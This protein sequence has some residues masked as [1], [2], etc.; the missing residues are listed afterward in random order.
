MLVKQSAA[1]VIDPAWFRESAERIVKRTEFCQ[2]LFD[3]MK[4]YARQAP[5]KRHPERLS[6]IVRD[7]RRI[8][9]DRIMVCDPSVRD[10]RLSVDV[11]EHCVLSAARPWSIV[12]LRPSNRRPH[13]E[14]LSNRQD[15]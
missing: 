3:N 13:R 4:A 8:V 15:P 2:R 5:L 12:A 1:G 14:S 7:A 9:A 11:P 6:K 10:V